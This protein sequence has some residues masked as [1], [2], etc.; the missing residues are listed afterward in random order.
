MV[1]HKMLWVLAMPGRA[2]VHGLNVEGL[3]QGTPDKF[4]IA[5][6]FPNALEGVC[7]VATSNGD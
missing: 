4:I 2:T 5:A 1:E 3:L 6:T 7:V